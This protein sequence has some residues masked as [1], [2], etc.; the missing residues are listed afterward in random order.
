MG[1]RTDNYK[2]S[3]VCTVI[4][5]GTTFDGTLTTAETVRVEGV[6]KG[7]VVSEGT[8]IVGCG[9]LVDGKIEAVNILVGGEVRGELFASGK[10]EVNPTGKIY[11]NLHTKALI[12]DDKALFRGTCEMLREEKEEKTKEKEEKTE[13]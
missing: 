2:A 7:N 9:G 12:V 11:G 5:K 10:I 3:K 1:K 13:E 6:V 8:F 4:G